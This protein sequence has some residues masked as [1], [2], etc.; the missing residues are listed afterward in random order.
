LNL[1]LEVPWMQSLRETRRGRR[2]HRVVINGLGDLELLAKRRFSV[3]QAEG[4]NVQQSL[5]YGLKLPT[6]ESDHADVNGRRADPHDQTGT[7]KLGLV[8]GY[9]WDRERI[10]DTVWASARYHRDLGG[11][12][13]MGDMLEADTAYGRWLIRPNEASQLGLNLAVGLHGEFHLADRLEGGR[14]A[15]NG[16]HLVG[17]QVTPILTKHNHQLRFG[18]F[19]PFARSGPG[20]H[21]DF[22]YEVR[23]AFETFF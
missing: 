21:A 15:E 9:A 5:I 8:L 12:F 2:P 20:D 11:G 19:V 17:V 23:F 14:S 1:M 6:G 4:L 10:E 16:H 7:G 13:R 3:R 18:I 22:P